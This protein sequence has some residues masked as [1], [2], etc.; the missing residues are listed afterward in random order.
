MSYNDNEKLTT[1]LL[2]LGKFY[3]LSEDA[4]C[5][6]MCFLYGVLD[7][8]YKCPIN[9]PCRLELNKSNNYYWNDDYYTC[10]IHKYRYY[11]S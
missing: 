5:S 4:Y 8:K 11:L 2:E 9:C 3:Y 6:C 10:V 1:P 7:D